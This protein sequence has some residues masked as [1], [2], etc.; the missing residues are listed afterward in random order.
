MN[1]IKSRR[2]PPT[3][4]TQIERFIPDDEIETHAT[5]I[6]Q[7]YGR[8]FKPITE[9]PVPIENIIDL[10]VDIPIVREAIPDHQ[11]SSVLAKLIARGYPYH[12]LEI[13]VNEDKQ[14]YFDKY[15]GTEQYSLAHEL[16]HLVLHID[17][18]ILNTLLLHDAE[19]QPII[20]CRMNSDEDRDRS[21]KW[22]EL[23]A[24][25]FAAFILMPQDLLRAACASMD[26]YHWP[27]LYTLKDQFQVTI[28][29][30]TNRLKELN[31]IAITP[32]RRLI[33]YQDQRVTHTRSL[34]E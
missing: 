9:P 24:E 8:K 34:W 33:P 11:G 13:I 17:R 22:K 4:M 1:K 21:A 18:G 31:L 3:V 27:N 30:L 7:K 10:V 20:L 16:G 25:R 29:A 15:K 19:E 6:L 5:S 28:S 32:D 12:T 26:I 2:I 23:Q 14:S